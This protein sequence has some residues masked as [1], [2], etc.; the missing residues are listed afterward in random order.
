VNRLT[1]RTDWGKMPGRIRPDESGFTNDLVELKVDRIHSFTSGR[2]NLF[3]N[4]DTG[5]LCSMVGYISNLDELRSRYSFSGESDTE[6]VVRLYY[7]IGPQVIEV[8]D[9]IFTVFIWDG[10]K[11][12]GYLFQ[13]EHASNLPL[14]YAGTKEQAVASTSLKEVLKEMP[15]GRELDLAAVYDFLEAKLI[16]PNESTFIKGVKK[17]CPGQYIL[18][19]R[20]RNSFTVRPL[21]RRAKKVPGAYARSNLIKSLGDSVKGLYKRVDADDLFC[22]LSGGFD[23]NIVL[24]FLSGSGKHVKAVTIGG[25]EKNEIPNAKELAGCYE[26]VEHEGYLVEEDMLNLLPDMIWR[27]EGYTCQRGLFLQY[28]LAEQLAGSRAGNIFLG[29][30]ADQALDRYRLSLFHNTVKRIKKLLRRFSSGKSRDDILEA[31]LRKK[32]SARCG[33]RWLPLKKF[34][35]DLDCILKKSGIMLNSFGVQGVYPFLNR[36]TITIARALGRGNRQKTFYKEKVLEALGEERS[37]LIR[38]EW[39]D[40]DIEYLF[41]GKKDIV[42]RLLGSAFAR[43][44][45]GEE[46]IRDIAASLVENCDL[47]LRILFVYVFNELFVSGK[48]DAKFDQGHIDVKLEELLPA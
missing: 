12:Q 40:T 13:D 31:L 47:V 30:C 35:A 20:A 44:V 43:D 21:R 2:K 28:E 42:S 32:R 1:V 48:F 36:N 3:Y 16:V 39:G 45:L 18:I 11:Q 29:D 33:K 19:D 23:S 5:V 10:K 38:K 6:L 26:N 41:E 4:P 8:L 22:T 9:G 34:D 24:S 46:S 15:P 17:L 27:L 25:K 37:R 7:L 14:Y